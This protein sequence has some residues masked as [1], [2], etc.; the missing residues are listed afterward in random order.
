MPEPDRGTTGLLGPLVSWQLTERDS[1]EGRDGG[2][3]GCSGSGDSP[4]TS[5]RPE[6]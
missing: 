4:I 2:H 3:E 5:T 6:A 1:A